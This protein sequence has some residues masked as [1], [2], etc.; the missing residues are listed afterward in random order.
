[1]GKGRGGPPLHSVTTC[2]LDGF[3]STEGRGVGRERSRP[4]GPTAGCEGAAAERELGGPPGDRGPRGPRTSERRGQGGHPGVGG[5]AVRQRCGV[6]HP[7]RQGTRLW[8]P[9]CCLRRKVK[10]PR[11][12]RQCD[13][14]VRMFDPFSKQGLGWPLRKVGGRWRDL[15]PL[16]IAGKFER[17]ENTVAKPKPEDS[18]SPIASQSPEGCLDPE[19]RP[20]ALP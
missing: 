13:A 12:C 4:R 9:R 17:A 7:S 10:G 14:A 16:V 6:S 1:M 18:A 19:P 11:D 8:E 20:L 3:L 2:W 15:Q 5:P